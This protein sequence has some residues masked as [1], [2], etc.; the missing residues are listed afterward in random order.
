MLEKYHSFISGIL[1]RDADA[2]ETEIMWMLMETISF[3][4][5]YETVYK[6]GIAFLGKDCLVRGAV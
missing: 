6:Y 4:D 1:G 3:N 2:M 5:A